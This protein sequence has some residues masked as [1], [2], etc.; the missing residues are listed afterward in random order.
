M[1]QKDIIPIVIAVVAGIAVAI[2]ADKVLF[3]NNAAQY[4]NVDNVPAIRTDFPM[5][6]TA[7]FNSQSID[8]TQIINISPNNSQQPFTGQ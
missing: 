8:P 1:K 5:P 4:T 7:Y 6:S 3:S 2:I